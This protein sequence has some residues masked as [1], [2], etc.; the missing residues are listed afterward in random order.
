MSPKTSILLPSQESLLHSLQHMVQYGLQSTVLMGSQGAGKTTIVTALV[1]KLDKVCSAFVSC[2]QYAGCN[3]IRRKILAQLLPEALFD[4]EL[5]LSD[6]LPKCADLLAMHTNIVLDDAHFLPLE[7]W[8]ECLALN[9]SLAVDKKVS[10]TFTV[11]PEFLP[12]LSTQLSESKLKLLLPVA[13]DALSEDEQESLYYAL[14]KHSDHSSLVPYGVMRKQLGLL[15]TTVGEVIELFSAALHNEQTEVVAK[16]KL[17][18]SLVWLFVLAIL[19]L[20]YFMIFPE[21]KALNLMPQL[22]MSANASKSNQAYADLLLAPYFEQRQA[23]A[24]LSGVS[25]EPVEKAVKKAANEVAV[26]RDTKSTKQTET[27]VH[28]PVEMNEKEAAA[29]V[30]KVA[31]KS[32]PVKPVSSQNEKLPVDLPIKGFVLQVASVQNPDSL[33]PIMK[34]LGASEQVRIAKYQQWWVVLLGDFDSIKEARQEAVRLQQDLALPEPWVRRWT[35]LSEF[36]LQ[37]GLPSS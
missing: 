5:P 32:K 14:L 17:L 27:P 9:R 23:H 28:K 6:T 4:D 8:L 10:F 22:T 18:P 29:E 20:G 26:T 34:K 31:T 12:E 24:P 35:D 3:E 21:S 2:P 33:V 15:P 1:N 36:Q 11:Q 16:S 25:L 37:Q 30:A 19:A 7:I 13:I